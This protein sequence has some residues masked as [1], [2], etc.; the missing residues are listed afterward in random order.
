MIH[1]LLDRELNDRT[2][3]KQGSKIHHE[4]YLYALLPSYNYMMKRQQY[5]F[6][7]MVTNT[8][9]LIYCPGHRSL[10]QNLEN[11]LLPLLQSLCA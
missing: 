3:Y 6:K 1:I 11:S 7:E 9:A 5:S 2:G 10:L 8:L 4:H